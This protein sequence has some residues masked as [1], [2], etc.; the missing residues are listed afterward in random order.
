MAQN[1]DPTP[2]IQRTY[3]KFRTAKE[4]G[5]TKDTR[6]S[7]TRNRDSDIRQRR[8]LAKKSWNMTN[9]SICECQN[10]QWRHNSCE[11]LCIATILM[12]QKLQEMQRDIDRQTNKRRLLHTTL[13]IRQMKWAKKSKDIE[14]LRNKIWKGVSYGLLWTECLCHPKIYAE[15]STHN[16]MVLGGRAFWS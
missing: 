2:R 6:Q 13:S 11:Y 12:K 3:V 10:S 5:W 8:I 1:Q 9:D 7:A 4:K 14:D 16:V 15:I